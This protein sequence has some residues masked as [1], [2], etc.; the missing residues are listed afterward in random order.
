MSKFIKSRKV[1]P[2]FFVRVMKKNQI[3]KGS[4]PKTKIH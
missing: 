1:L 4:G 2:F 3:M